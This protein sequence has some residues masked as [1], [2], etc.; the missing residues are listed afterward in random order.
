MNLPLACVKCNDSGY[1]AFVT[2]ERGQIQWVPP[3]HYVPG[4]YVT[5]TPCEC[6][7]G[8]RVITESP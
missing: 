8:K 7:N 4:P 2:T 1:L 3:H 6:A 5:L